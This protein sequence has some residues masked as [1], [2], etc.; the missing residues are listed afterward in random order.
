MAVICFR[1]GN[2]YEGKVAHAVIG[3]APAHAPQQ[4][5]GYP[6]VCWDMICFLPVG[7]VQGNLCSALISGSI[8]KQTSHRQTCEMQTTITPLKKF[9][10]SFINSYSALIDPSQWFYFPA[11][12]KIVGLLSRGW[13][14]GCDLSSWSIRMPRLFLQKPV[15]RWDQAA[16]VWKCGPWSENKIDFAIK[17][18]VLRFVST[19][20]VK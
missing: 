17:S 12:V 11:E 7:E 3:T 20:Y 13:P 15:C 2:F 4:V 16:C 19:N 14:L 6:L 9:A 8:R 1:F 10:I 5:T 18:V